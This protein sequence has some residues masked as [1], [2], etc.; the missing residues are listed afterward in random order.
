MGPTAETAVYSHKGCLQFKGG[1]GW[2]VWG[3]GVGVLQTHNNSMYCRHAW[4]VDITQHNSE[5][6]SAHYHNARQVKGKLAVCQAVKSLPSFLSLGAL[7]W[8]KD[9]KQSNSDWPD[10]KEVQMP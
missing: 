10:A 9:F 1:G 3:G 6:I 7:H 5:T 8:T 2:C 4:T